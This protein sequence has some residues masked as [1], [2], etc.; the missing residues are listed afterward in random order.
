MRDLVATAP[1]QFSNWEVL[2]VGFLLALFV[3]G[4]FAFI[5][6]VYPSNRILPDQYYDIKHPDTLSSVGKIIGVNYFRNILLFA[7]WPRK[8]AR[9]KYFIGTK[10]GLSNFVF[11][12]RQSEFGHLA[13]F[14]VITL[15][16]ILLAA[17]GHIRLVAI[18]TVIIVIGNLYPIILQRIHRVRIQQLT[19]HYTERSSQR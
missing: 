3:T 8:G 2:L 13:A 5:G 19:Q 11:Q 14:I 9:K 10:T 18:V 7:F 17:N 4:I 12:T 15:C 6:F 16:S 1:E